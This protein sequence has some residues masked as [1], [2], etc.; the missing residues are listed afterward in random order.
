MRLDTSPPSSSKAC[1]PVFPVPRPDGR[2]YVARSDRRHKEFLV[3]AGEFAHSGPVGVS[4]AVGHTV[5]LQIATP[6]VKRCLVT[7][8]IPPLRPLPAADPPSAAAACVC[9][10]QRLLLSKPHSRARNGC[11]HPQIPRTRPHRDRYTRYPN[12]SR[13]PKTHP[14]TRYPNPP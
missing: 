10:N 12:P 11:H 3:L 2:V 8:D 13:H 4:A 6:L 7:R 9:H 5:C 1:T 14:S